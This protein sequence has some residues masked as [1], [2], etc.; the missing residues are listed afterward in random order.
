MECH[1]V[2]GKQWARRG[3]GFTLIELL[4]VMTILATLLTLAVPRYYGSVHRA[5]EAVLKEDLATVRDAIQKFRSDTGRWPASLDELVARRY[6]KQVPVDP[7]TDSR[8]S[9]IAMPPDAS[10]EV[11]IADVRSGAPGKARDGSTYRD[12]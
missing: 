5:K 3:R 8:A 4:V 10:D 6:L 12:W 2:S 7:V 11:G 1:T 9:W